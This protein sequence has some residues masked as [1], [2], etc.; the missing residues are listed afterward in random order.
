MFKCMLSAIFSSEISAKITL[1]YSDYKQDLIITYILTMS[2]S[3]IKSLASLTY[4][5]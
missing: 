4:P 2:F 3:D 5:Y 1:Q